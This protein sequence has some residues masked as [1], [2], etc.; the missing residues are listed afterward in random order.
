[1]LV[2]GID[3]GSLTTGYGLVEKKD[4]RLIYVEAGKI[5][6][7]YS[8]PFSER[9]YKIYKSLLEVIQTYHPEEVSIE[10]IFFAKN[11]KSALKI[12]HARGAAL[13]AA[14]QRGLKVFEYTP[15]Q[16]K[17]SVVGYGRATKEQVRSMVTLILKLDNQKFSL[18]TSDALAIAICH[19]NWVRF[20]DTN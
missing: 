2:L 1:M 7:S 15:L 5:S 19:H 10:D 11:V 3:P 9:I 8:L 16:I 4:N 13:I 17:Q 6:F 14:I 18:D 20:E 12:G